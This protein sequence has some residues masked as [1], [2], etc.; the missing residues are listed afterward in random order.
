MRGL[1]LYFLAG[2]L[3]VLAWE[4]VAP[5]VGFSLMRGAWPAAG[6]SPAVTTRYETPLQFV[7]RTH[8]G[9]RLKL[10]TTAGKRQLP[11]PAA[12][13]ACEPAVSPLATRATIAGRC[14]A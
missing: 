2:I 12:L 11:A 5:P 9:D 6:A 14:I 10:P 3:V 13:V 1:T 7:D 4:F 8:K